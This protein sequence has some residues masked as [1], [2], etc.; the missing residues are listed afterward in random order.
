MMSGKSEVVT[1][2]LFYNRGVKGD[3]AAGK[4]S[5]LQIN[6]ILSSQRQSME[7]KNCLK[8]RYRCLVSR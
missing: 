3:E 8:D 6:S 4:I 1:I 2:G 5:D 7:D